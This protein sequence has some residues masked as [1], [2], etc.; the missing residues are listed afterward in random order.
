[1]LFWGPS[2]ASRDISRFK[3]PALEIYLLLPAKPVAHNYGRSLFNDRLLQDKVAFC[4]GLL[5]PRQSIAP[6]ALASDYLIETASCPHLPH[7][8]FTNTASSA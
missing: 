4:F 5:G 7:A 8:D 2:A 3:V 6:I 1:M